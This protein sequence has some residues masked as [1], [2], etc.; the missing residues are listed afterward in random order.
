MRAAFPFCKPDAPAARPIASSQL[1]R[2]IKTMKTSGT[3]RALAVLFIGV[4]GGLYLHF[5]QSRWVADGR[6]A[7][8]ATQG[9][10]F[11]FIAAHNSSVTM[12][13]VGTVLA[14][15]GYGLYELIAAGF[16]RLIPPSQVEE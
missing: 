1:P 5:R 15:A 16:T 12:L 9:R 7:F 8:L 6:D 14:V 4:I 10:R 11:D 13:I 2:I 3:G